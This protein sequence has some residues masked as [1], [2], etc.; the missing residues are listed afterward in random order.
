M[1][2]KLLAAAIVAATIAIAA[3]FLSSAQVV[4]VAALATA[5]SRWVAIALIA[6]IAG[7][8]RSLTTAAGGPLLQPGSDG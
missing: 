3:T 1:K 8:R 2:N 7:W 6:A 4:P 5:V